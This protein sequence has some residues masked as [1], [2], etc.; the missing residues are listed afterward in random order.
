MSGLGSAKDPR[1]SS[2]HLARAFAWSS[3]PIEECGHA[4]H[5][6]RPGAFIEGLEMAIAPREIGT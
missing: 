1:S 6:E 4:P 2:R 3:D 5:I